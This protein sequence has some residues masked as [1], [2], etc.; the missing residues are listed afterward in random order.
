MSNSKTTK[1]DKIWRLEFSEKQ[2]WLRLDNGSHPENTNGFTTIYSQCTD[3]DYKILEAY[4]NRVQ[5]DVIT[6]QYILKCAVELTSFTSNL[7]EY[8]LK[9]SK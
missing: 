8:N 9:I 2:Q 4:I 5:R 3:L 6:V 7:N 1:E